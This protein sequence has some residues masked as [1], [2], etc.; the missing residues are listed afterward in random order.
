MQETVI[1]NADY[2][3]AEVILCKLVKYEGIFKVA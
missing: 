2:I 1:S 3:Y